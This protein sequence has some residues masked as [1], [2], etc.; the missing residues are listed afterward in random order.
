MSPGE[1]VSVLTAEC[2]RLLAPRPGGRF[3]DCTV[4]GGGH[5]AEIL[6]RTAPDGP[7]LALDADPEAVERARERLSLFGDRVHVVHAN[8]RFVD[9]VARDLGF[10][11]ADGILMDLGLSSDQLA[12][13]N[14][15][16]SFNRDEPLDMRF[17]PTQGEAAADYL[18]SASQAE[19]E[20]TLRGFG[21]EP[22]ARRIATAIVASRERG[23]LRTS[24]ELAALVRRVHGGRQGA[25][26]PATRTF[27]ALRI[28]VN[29]ELGTLRDALPRAIGMLRHGGRLAVISFHS[30]EDRIVKTLFRR[31]AGRE[32]DPT[33][34]GLPPAAKEP[35][36]IRILTPRPIRPSA[37]EV[38]G[39]ARSRS[40]RL[41][42]AER[43]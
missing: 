43:I 39:N 38:A 6:Q 7:H 9:A 41:R 4:D 30:L 26:D 15:G 31:L 40:A 23:G 3:V 11:D 25:I 29:D 12:A 5:S 37:A 8:F 10:S 18:A 13:P 42:V 27:Q 36:E 21:E 24:G 20:Q 17:D 33:P 1:H 35:A 28:A 22:A 32:P 16:F 2:I 14:R 34:R 19:I